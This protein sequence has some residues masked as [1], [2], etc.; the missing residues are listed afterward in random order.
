MLVDLFND[1]ESK[2]K[3][4]LNEFDSNSSIKVNI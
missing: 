2:E 3:V 1:D 4:I